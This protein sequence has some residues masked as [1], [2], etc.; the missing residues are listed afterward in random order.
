MASVWP[1]LFVDSEAAAPTSLS[2]P[3]LEKEMKILLRKSMKELE[4]GSVCLR[5]TLTL[6][7]ILRASPTGV[8]G[9]G[10]LF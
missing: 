6:I 2:S 7:S 8:R 3:N 10:L 9:K 5:D 4:I 1:F